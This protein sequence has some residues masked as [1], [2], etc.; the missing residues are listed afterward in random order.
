MSLKIRIDLDR[1]SGCALCVDG[2]PVP[3]LAFDEAKGIPY[4]IDEPGCL[5]CRTCE[6]L[7]STGALRVEFPEY[8]LKAD[9]DG[10]LQGR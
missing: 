9:M 4:V 3:S 2:C 10:G 1:C 7:C 5:I 8:E 6:T